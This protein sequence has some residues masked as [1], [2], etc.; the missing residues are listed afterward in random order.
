MA[1]RGGGTKAASR[2]RNSRVRGRA[3][4]PE[5]PWFGK[6]VDRPL[7]CPSQAS[8]PRPRPAAPLPRRRSNGHNSGAIARAPFDRGP[9]CGSWRRARSRPRAR[10][11]ASWPRPRARTRPAARTGAVPAFARRAVQPLADRCRF[12]K[13]HTFSL[14]AERHSRRSGTEVADQYRGGCFKHP[15]DNGAVEMQV[16]IE[17]YG[18]VGVSTIHE[19]NN[20][21]S[22]HW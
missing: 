19:P 13:P 10:I 5:R 22:R 12:A 2:S 7:T 18:I 8:H 1:M 9:R 17:I 3:P 15:I 11:G 21:N 4:L 6:G 16:G 20:G 14:G